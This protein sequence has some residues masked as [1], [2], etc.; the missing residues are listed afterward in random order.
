[1]DKM[2]PRVIDFVIE[3]KLPEYNKFLARQKNKPTT[4][5]SNTIEYAA[6]LPYD[7]FILKNLELNRLWNAKKLTLNEIHDAVRA[8]IDYQYDPVNKPGYTS[9]I[10]PM[11]STGRSCTRRSRM[12]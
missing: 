9:T 7:S 10:L 11:I 4:K 1:M 6:K 12:A 3:T 5:L 8:I 2:D